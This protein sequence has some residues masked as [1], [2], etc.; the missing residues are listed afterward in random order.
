MIICVRY[1]IFRQARYFSYFVE[2]NV[3]A[4][5]ELT[6]STNIN[7]LAKRV[8]S[9]A[10]RSMA[11]FDAGDPLK[12]LQAV[13]EVALGHEKDWREFRTY[14]INRLKDR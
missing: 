9:A 3:D 10:K 13:V 2:K 11:K 14:L 8:K 4:K 5:G 12:Y 7:V 1:Y 6:L